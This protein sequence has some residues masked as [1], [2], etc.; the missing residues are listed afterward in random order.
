MN[1]RLLKA[2]SFIGVLFFL[3]GNAKALTGTAYF[4]ND[5]LA[6][7]YVR[8][9]EQGAVFGGM[10]TPPLVT[11]NPGGTGSSTW[12]T[13]AAN[14]IGWYGNGVGTGAGNT[15]VKYSP[16]SFAAA[17]ASPCFEGPLY[18]GPGGSY[19]TGAGNLGHTNVY[20]VLEP[21]VPPQCPAQSFSWG[22]SS[23]CTG[24][25]PI[26]AVGSS[27]ALTN[28]KA[29]ASG[30]ATASCVSGAWQVTSPSCGASMA[31]PAGLTA[32]DGTVSYGINLSWGAISG[33]SLYRVQFRVQGATAWQGD[34]YAGAAT[35]HN[36]TGLAD[37]R[38]FE[39]QVRAENAAGAGAWSPIEAG[40]IRKLMDPQFVSQVGIPTRIGVGQSF[41]YT[42]VW[43]NNGAETWTGGAH[44]TGPFNP[45]NSSVWTTGFVAFPGSTANSA[46]VTASLTAV[47]P[48]TP[49]TYPLQ[50]GMQK[51]G[52]AYGAAST[53][54]NVIVVGTPQCTAATPDITT[55]YNANGTVTITLAGTSS[56]ESASIKVWGGLNG[57]DDVRDY[58]M[59][60][61]SNWTATFPVANH[62]SV[63]E[64]KI[65]VEARVAN[66]FFAPVMCAT[67]G[68]T[69]QQ[70]P[71]PQI[72][73]TPTMGSYTDGAS[74]GFVAS[75]AS[76]E[77]AKATV[78]LGSY[79]A[80]RANVELVLADQT[81]KGVA[82][83]NLAPGTQVS[84]S[85]VNS[86][87]AA[88][89]PAW[90]R[91]PA[92]VKVTYADPAAASQGKQAL[93]P[94][95][96][97]LPPVSMQVSASGALGLPVTVNAR[98]HNANAFDEST[99][100]QFVGGL[101]LASDQSTVQ[102]F[103]GTDV[104]GQ[105][106]APGLDYGQLFSSQLVAVARVAPPAGVSLLVPMEF[107]SAPFVLPVQ[108]PASVDAT[109]G[110]RED[111][112]KI[113]WTAVATG[114]DIRYRLFRED[115]ELTPSGGVSA[116]EFVDTPP[117]RGT[118]YNYRVKTIIGV[119]TSDN[120]GADSGYVPACRAVRLIGASL[121][122]DMSAI[123]GLLERWDC[124]SGLTATSAIDAQAPADMPY[125][126]SKMY[127]S[128][129][130]PVPTSL[131][132]GAHVLHLGME[133]AGVTINASRTYDVP[134]NLDRASIS[135]NSMTIL[136]DGSP[137]TDGL[138]ANSIGRF[139][140][141][142]E[143]GDGIGFAEEIK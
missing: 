125:S 21:Y 94:V 17:K 143:G 76:G 133:S 139:G 56:V 98:V 109:D 134:F 92:F 112:V 89:V 84:L 5:T 33:A 3:V 43:K 69:V 32:T 63:G 12:T 49:G 60:L 34:L 64:T 40:N 25:A 124:L 9:Q 1:K 45:A 14:S 38:V 30:S 130:V 2:I 141:R 132:D 110:T 119:A 101:R 116:L 142:M 79:T 28:T 42:Q 53:L 36:W 16:V 117:T 46:T 128:F 4:K 10:P 19:T 83:N 95:S 26:T 20:V 11:V 102:S 51:S 37:E 126:G 54:A 91:V 123:N 24:S 35:A 93:I 138:N 122:A 118:T 55:T 41:A 108:A 115:A 129:S 81:P 121:N 85:A 13:L 111:D 31:A 113:N 61:G 29:G 107:L 58:A 120:D 52:T 137:A 6:V 87:F 68:V 23:Y 66:P 39:F 80:L 44:G 78:D 100:G 71:V 47:A 106:A 105:W 136:Y 74:A 86:V 27:F 104:Q 50:R 73:L 114:S 135:V 70:L 77:Y 140:V 99:Y 97:T 96:I 59:T 7:W 22:P 18:G 75:R 62:L 131:V 8:A 82:V 88:S 72:T 15:C 103:I 90:T 67:S 65:N 127:R 48:T 57:Q